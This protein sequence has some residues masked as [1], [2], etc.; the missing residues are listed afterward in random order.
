MTGLAAAASGLH[1]NDIM[2]MLYEAMSRLHYSYVTA[3][4][5]AAASDR[6]QAVSR[7]PRQPGENKHVCSSYDS[8]H[9]LPAS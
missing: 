8:L 6:R 2:A 7:L 3:I 1:W 9:L 5:T 4:A